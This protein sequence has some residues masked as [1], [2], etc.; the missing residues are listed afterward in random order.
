MK[1]WVCLIVY[2]VINV[3]LT[4]YLNFTGKLGGLSSLNRGNSVVGVCAIHERLDIDLIQKPEDR[5]LN[6]W[7]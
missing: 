6:T 1:S 3:L 2:T 5:R 4:F 7:N